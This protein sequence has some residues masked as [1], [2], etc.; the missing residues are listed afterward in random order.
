MNTQLNQVI[1]TLGAQLAEDI[2]NAEV[3]REAYMFR[4]ADV[5]TQQGFTVAQFDTD[6]D[7][8]VLVRGALA[9]RNELLGR[10]A[11]SKTEVSRFKTA[12]HPKVRGMVEDIIAEAQRLVDEDPL[13]EGKRRQQVAES[14]MAQLKNDDVST[15][16]TASDNVLRKYAEA[17]SN[18]VDPA[19]A[20]GL[21]KSLKSKLNGKACKAAFTEDSLKAALAAIDGLQVI[22]VAAPEPITVVTPAA[23]PHDDLTSAL[24]AIAGMEFLPDAAKADMVAAL[25][26][27]QA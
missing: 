23:V 26:A 20:D 25:V 1:E 15:V 5:S 11:P 19:S 12:A 16:E 17:A 13:T 27:R 3:S 6:G 9:K 24:N 22:P 18:A 2:T 4:M 8:D 21:L 14:M 10:G 7:G